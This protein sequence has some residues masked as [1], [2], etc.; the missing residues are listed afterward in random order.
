[1]ANA[2]SKCV[3]QTGANAG[4]VAW[5]AHVL[6]SPI[7]AAGGALFGAV[8]HLSKIVLDN[9]GTAVL[10]TN[11]PEAA[12]ETKTVA[13][14]LGYF[15]SYAVAWSVLTYTCLPLTLSHMVGLTLTSVLTGICIAIFFNC[16]H[17]DNRRI[18]LEM[19]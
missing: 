9:F 14:A 15:G 4:A 8:Q 16:L 11:H 1:M 3:L 5:A 10:Q 18:N 7:G 19:A 17:G 12:A 13:W 6:G 2:I